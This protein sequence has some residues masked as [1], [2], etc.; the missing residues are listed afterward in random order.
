MWKGEERGGGLKG[1]L[2]EQ[3]GINRGLRDMTE[4]LSYLHD[5]LTLRS[6]QS[7]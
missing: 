7:D 1:E 6:D 5:R 2:D 4:D 3:K